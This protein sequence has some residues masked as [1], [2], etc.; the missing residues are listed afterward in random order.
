MTQLCTF[1]K[2][3]ALGPFGPKWQRTESI[4]VRR[5]TMLMLSVFC[6]NFSSASAFNTRRGGSFRRVHASL[7]AETR[8]DTTLGIP[9]AAMA[10]GTPWPKTAAALRGWNAHRHGHCVTR[11]TATKART[12]I[13]LRRS[14]KTQANVGHDG[15]AK[16]LLDVACVGPPRDPRR[17]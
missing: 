3:N 12:R 7:K 13:L 2:K 16:A 4:T 8:T 17:H 5:T 15:L 11:A 10:C 1:E 9:Q 14:F 6:Y